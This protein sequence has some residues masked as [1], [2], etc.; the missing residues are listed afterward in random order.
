MKSLLNLT[1]FCLAVAMLSSCPQETKY[2][3]PAIADQHISFTIDG[4]TQVLRSIS[5]EA[6]EQS[7]LLFLEENN[8]LT[9]ARNSNDLTTRFGI[10]AENLP[11][12]LDGDLVVLR[13]KTFVPAVVTVIGAEMSGSIYCPHT[14]GGPNEIVEY[15][16]L[17]RV[18]EFS[19][20]G[21]I[22]GVFKTDPS[23]P[24]NAVTITNGT[25]ELI[26]PIR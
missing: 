8:F 2:E 10:N 6:Y 22:K 9:L 14:E 4:Q 3:V 5:N 19:A 11:L 17:I 12:E 25:F 15:Q 20:D 7:A 23:A 18:D 21:R 24:D 16:A 26:V 13:T 1:L